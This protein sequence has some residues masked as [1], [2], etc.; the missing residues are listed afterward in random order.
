[1]RIIYEKIQKSRRTY[2]SY[3]VGHIT[4]YNLNHSIY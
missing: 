3:S 4:A 1:M 2:N